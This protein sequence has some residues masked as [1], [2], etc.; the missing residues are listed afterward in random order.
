MCFSHEKDV[1]TR[2]T[3][4]NQSDWIVESTRS[5]TIGVVRTPAK[6]LTTYGT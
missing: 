3:F 2:K 1:T 6:A 5:L 4:G